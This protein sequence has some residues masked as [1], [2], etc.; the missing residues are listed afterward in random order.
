MQNQSTD[1]TLKLSGKI[2]SIED[3]K[4]VTVLIKNLICAGKTHIAIDM[5]DVSEVSGSFSGF[6]S[7]TLNLIQKD[8]G[9]FIFFN[10]NFLIVDILKVCGFGNN[11]NN[12]FVP[13]KKE[14][15]L[16]LVIEDE[17]MIRELT[18][19]FLAE[20]GISS[21]EADNGLEGIRKFMM[22][23]DSID[24]IV[25]DIE[26]PIIDGVQMLQRITQIEP[27]V[28][29]IVASGFTLENKVKMI[30]EIKG[31]AIFLH[32]PYLYS[33]LEKAV[34]SLRKKADVR[35]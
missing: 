35:H 20:M 2:V 22:F 23:K 5:K 13:S 32:K 8:K 29:V 9:E 18:K 10:A 26:M 31:D 6:L 16:A 14:E 7:E 28:K 12:E 34:K 19:G 3:C 25:M 24:F 1:F 27:D 30:R 17:P 11:I 15:K 21:F 33:E 4:R